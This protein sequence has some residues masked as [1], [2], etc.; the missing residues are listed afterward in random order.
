MQVSS[1]GFSDSGQLKPNNE[2]SYLCN[3]EALLYLV[4][5]GVGGQACGEQAS[6]LAVSSVEKYVKESRAKEKGQPDAPPEGYTPEQ[7]RLLAAASYANRKL[8]EAAQQNHGLKGMG[9]TLIGVTVEKDHLACVNVGD[10]RLYRIRNNLIQQLTCDHTLAGQKKRQGLLSS[11]E[12]RNHPYRHILTSVLG[13]YNKMPQIDVY[14]VGIEEN[15]LFLLCTDGLHSVLEDR[16]LLNII[17]SIKDR[18]LFKI[19]LSLVLNAN[20]AGGPDNITIVLIDFQA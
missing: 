3:D 2:D 10:S 8:H 18:S 6:R 16:Q 4:A 17:A 7:N 19:G 1:F 15:D 13:G 14:Q 9:T 11:E 12:A 20:L 5:D